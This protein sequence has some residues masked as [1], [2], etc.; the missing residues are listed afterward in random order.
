MISIG[1]RF[2]IPLSCYV[3]GKYWNIPNINI[4]F[5][6]IFVSN[7]GYWISCQVATITRFPDRVMVTGDSV[8]CYSYSTEF[9]FWARYIVGWNKIFS[10]I[11]VLF[12]MIRNKNHLQ[13]T[14]D[15]YDPSSQ[16]E[17]FFLFSI[18]IYF[19]R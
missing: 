6:K 15:S 13:L 17:T 5:P 10:F 8:K 7:G 14:W 12:W 9:Y 4:E 2:I 16:Y 18:C 19:W 1:I 11:S 3:I